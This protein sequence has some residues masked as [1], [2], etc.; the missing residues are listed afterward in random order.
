M[1]QPNYIGLFE[2]YLRKQATA[3]EIRLLV[4]WIKE[5]DSFHRFM[6]DA[7][8]DASFEMEEALSEKLLADIK[9]TIYRPASAEK[10]KKTQPASKFLFSSGFFRVA[11]V[12]AFL[13]ATSLGVYFYRSEPTLPDAVVWVEKGQKA[14]LILPDGSKVWINA[15]S[16]LTYGSEFTSRKRTLHLEGEAYFE[17]ASDIHRPFIVETGEV[18][19]RALGTRFNVKAYPDETEVSTVLMSGKVEVATGSD[20]LIMRPNE[21]IWFDKATRKMEKTRISDTERYAGW[22]HN[23]LAFQAETLEQIAVTLERFYNVKIRFES[24]ALKHYRFTG[25]LGNTSLESILQI[26]SFTS[27]LSYEL[28]DSLIVLHENKREKVWY[29]KALK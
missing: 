24:E 20:R 19:V 28:T 23:S 9:R 7:W 3:D 21:K 8:K 12:L 14:N 5:S 6:N 13:L 17:V 10:M 15:D 18:S 29:E 1:E 2:K 25:T 27:P 11:A 16:R 22:R 26:L 4:R